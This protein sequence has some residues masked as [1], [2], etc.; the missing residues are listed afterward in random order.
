MKPQYCSYDIDS[1]LYHIGTNA[2]IQWEEYY[3]NNLSFDYLGLHEHMHANNTI[4][5]RHIARIVRTK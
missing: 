1:P 4:N 3:G 5:I 2:Y